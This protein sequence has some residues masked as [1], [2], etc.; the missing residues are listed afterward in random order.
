MGLAY[1]AML[2]LV[3]G[4]VEALAFIYFRVGAA[5]LDHAPAYALPAARADDLPLAEW[6]THRHPWGA[7]HRP[8]SRASHRNWCFDARYSANGYG[9]R[10]VERPRSGAGRALFLGD[11]FVEGYT[12]NDGE[13]LTALLEQRYGRPVLNFGSGG[14][15]GPLQAEILYRELAGRFE[16]RHLFVGVLPDNDF[17]DNDAEFWKDTAEYRRL[18]RPY[19]GSDGVTPVYAREPPSGEE[20]RPAWQWLVEGARRYT[21]SFGLA[22]EAR[23]VLL[24]RSHRGSLPPGGYAGYRDA[25]LEQLGHVL[26]S[27]DRIASM[28]RANG[29]AVTVVLIP[30]PAD[31]ALADREVTIRPAIDE[32]AAGAGVALLD[33]R[34]AMPYDRDLFRACDGHWSPAGNA[35]AAE[36]IHGFLP[37]F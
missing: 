3:A 10:D 26:G 36:A 15:F 33:L 29:R 11:S 16:H 35:A 37:E 6:Y 21:W 2:V 14:H 28:A 22:K 19:Y 20:P 24:E 12:V 9:A 32:W 1:A 23:R 7:W 5:G 8:S 25:T 4:S 17:T 30:R 18:Y 13:R 34:E 27:L 31:Y